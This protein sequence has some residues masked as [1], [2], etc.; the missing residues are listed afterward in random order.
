MKLVIALLIAAAFG[1][2]FWTFLNWF[3]WEM[4]GL[5][6]AEGGSDC[7]YLTRDFALQVGLPWLVWLGCCAVTFSRF[8]KKN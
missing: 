6:C 5:E 8:W 7:A 4:A 3:V 1:L 2:L